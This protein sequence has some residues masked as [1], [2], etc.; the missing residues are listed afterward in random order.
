MKP[1]LVFSLLLLLNG[2]WLANAAPR[3]PAPLKSVSGQ[4]IIHDQRGNTPIP[5]SPDQQFMDLAP[6]FLVVSC[7]RIKQALYAELGAERKWRGVIHA[8][9]RPARGASEV[10]QIHVDRFGSAWIYR[11]DL[12]QQIDRTQFIRTLVQVLLLEMANRRAAERSAEI[13]LW[14]SEGLTQRLLASRE[15]ELI[16]PPPTRLIGSMLVDP[17]MILTRDPDPLETARRI[18]RD[19]PPPTLEDLSWPTLDQFTREQATVFQVS[20]QL[21]VAELLRLKEGPDYLRNFVASLAL[22]Y[23]WQTTFS[24]VYQE[25]FPNQLAL[26]KWWTLQATYFVGRDHQQLWTPAES[27]QKLAALLH[28]PVAVRAAAGELPAR[29]EVSLQVIIREWDTPRQLATL[30]GKLNELALA[31]RR[32]APQFIALVNDY[33]TVLDEYIQQRKRSA[34]TFGNFF[35]LTPSIK[36]VAQQTLQQLDALDARR[37]QI[38]I[39]TN[40]LAT[41]Q[42]GENPA[43]P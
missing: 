13:P 16:L 35:T 17:K 25:L 7:E 38:S 43:F 21:F 37:A 22:F 11:L 27:T 31:R 5:A 42:P 20:A 30:P 15:V 4:F 32:V 18:L 8:T 12:P 2:G 39:Q 10:A 29:T 40:P 24:R 6:S 36:K 28:T 1:A 34:A 33:A 14:L 41:N 26:E 23:N 19:R 3:V 9:I